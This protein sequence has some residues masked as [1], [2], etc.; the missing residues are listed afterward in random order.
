MKNSESGRLATLL[1]AL[2]P[3]RFK[4]LPLNMTM[5]NWSKK[6]LLVSGIFLLS[7]ILWRLVTVPALHPLR[8]SPDQSMFVAIGQ[9]I[10]EGKR[11]YIDF[12]DVNPPL[13]FYIHIAPVL[14]AK[15]LAVTPPQAFWYTVTFLWLYSVIFSL[16]LL[17]RQSNHRESFVFMPLIVSFSC[18]TLQ[19]CSDDEFGQREHI[20]LLLFIPLFIVRWLRWQQLNLPK[21]ATIVAA[22]IAAL[23]LF[24]KPS[25]LITLAVLELAWLIDNRRWRNLFAPEMIVLIVFGIIYAGCLLA[26]PQAMKNGYFGM[27]VPVFT[28]GYGEYGTSLMF[29]FV[30]WGPYWKDYF[31]LL[32]YTCSLGVILGRFS[33]LIM[34]LMAFTLLGFASYLLQGQPWFNHALPFLAG[35]YMLAGVEA[36]IIVF[37]VRQLIQKFVK[38]FDA[39]LLS[40]LCLWQL[41]VHN[42]DVTEQKKQV[43]EAP[44]LTLMNIG[45]TVNLPKADLPELAL[46]IFKYTEPGEQVLIMTR[47]IAPGYPLLLQTRRR[48]ASRYLHAMLLPTTIFA[49]DTTKSQVMKDKMDGFKEQILA[50]YREDIENNKPPLI[51]IQAPRIYDIVNEGDFIRNVILYDYQYAG[52]VED[53]RIYVRKDLPNC[54]PP[55][56]EEH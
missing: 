3:S 14:L 38:V 17:W 9:L 15:Y 2:K 13:A 37:I 51:L 23:G 54:P 31:L 8:I 19:L 25:Y 49:R 55:I 50:E 10:L 53:H 11:P 47:S 28:L 52:T 4:T 1:Q 41:Q 42:N 30:G 36:A 26:M 12:F 35:V 39:I 24:M 5:D 40:A 21:T 45:Y 20:Y 22:L 34:P 16:W 29:Q 32:I 6:A 56:K 48:P 18:L 46:E 44:K 33:T 7:L 43:K 27:M